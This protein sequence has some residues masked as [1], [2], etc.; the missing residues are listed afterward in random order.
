MCYWCYLYFVQD[1]HIVLVMS[2]YV[3]DNSYPI[4]NQKFG[5]EPEFYDYTGFYIAITI[6]TIVAALLIFVSLIFCKS[7][8][9]M[10]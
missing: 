7:I 6:C 1:N 9:N 2:S 4:Y 5:I 10:I 8:Q 3:E